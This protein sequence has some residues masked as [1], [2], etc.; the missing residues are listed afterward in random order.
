MNEGKFFFTT[1]IMTVIFSCALFSQQV[2]FTVGTSDSLEPIS[3]YIYGTNQLLSEGGDWTALRQGG[4]RFTG[5]NWE[6]NA[7]NAGSD[8]NQESDDYLVDVAGI[9]PDSSAVPGIVTSTFQNQTINLGAFSLVTLQMAGY[10]AKDKNGPVSAEE[11]APSPRWVGVQF[12][13]GSLFTLHPDTSDTSVYMDEY[14]NFLVNRFGE[15]STATGVKAY[16]LDNEPS[17]WPSTHPRIHPDTTMCQ[18]IIQKS[19]ALAKA[20]KEIDPSAEIFGPA[21]YGFNAYTGFQNAPD[22]NAVSRGKLYSWFIDY[23]LDMMKQ[24]SAS[25]GKRLLDVLDLHWYPEAIGDHRIIDA[26]ATTANDA[27]ARVQAPRTLWDKSYTENSWIGQSGKAFLPL[28]PRLMKSINTYYPGTKLSFSE[29]SYGGE[30]DISGA[31]AMA[32]VLGI[33]AKYGVY[34]ASFWELGSPSA[35]VSS[36]YKMYRN[37]DGNNSTF[38]D[39]YMQCQA[40]DSANCSIYG[41][42]ESDASEIHLI[43]INKDMNQSVTGNFTVSS[44]YKIESGKVW[45]LLRY[46]TQIVEGDDVPNIVNNSFSYLIESGSVNH[47][48]LKVSGLVGVPQITETPLTFYLRTFPNP[49]NPSCKIEYNAPGNSTASIEIYSVMGA[50]VRRYAGLSRQGSLYWNATDGDNRP[51]ASGVYFAVLRN[52]EG[53]FAEQKLIFLK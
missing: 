50:L 7:S 20:V 42:Y 22:W 9:N 34:F 2:T 52:D 51:V 44:R 19:I 23:Y 43:V 37:Y 6:N 36:A 30:D 11:T 49:F 4:N 5:Y 48:V 28:I 41:S 12:Q 10:V 39:L 17:L 16:S 3:P 29:F 14:V 8:Y 33:F 47:F 18:E 31:I 15:A 40:S 35:Y 27:V 32:D 13:K 45:K 46:S 38:G 21:L 24:A 53:I 25:Y 26:D 1:F